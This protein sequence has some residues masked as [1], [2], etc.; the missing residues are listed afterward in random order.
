MPRSSLI[1]VDEADFNERVKN[2]QKLG[3]LYDV[4]CDAKD[5]ILVY[6]QDPEEF[7]PVLEGD[8]AITEEAAAIWA[9][10][11]ITLLLE[12]HARGVF[13]GATALNRVVGESL[14]GASLLGIGVL[15]NL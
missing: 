2:L 15:G 5:V 14:A 11:V 13:I 8:G 6:D 1:T 4:F 10:K 3:I 9:R 7:A 12:C